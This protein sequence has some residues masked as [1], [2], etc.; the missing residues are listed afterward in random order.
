MM[1][2]QETPHTGETTMSVVFGEETTGIVTG[3]TLSGAEL[4]TITTIDLSKGVTPEA[5]A[6]LTAHCEKHGCE[7]YESSTLHFGEIAEVWEALLS[8]VFEP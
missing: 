4:V 1:I 5:C 3:S 8:E 7:F 2:T 6:A